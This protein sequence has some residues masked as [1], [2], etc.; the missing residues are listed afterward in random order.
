MKCPFCEFADTRVVETR[1]TTEDVTRRRREC[2]NCKKRFTTY[3]RVELHPLI[4]I[5]KAGVREAFDR[6]KVKSGVLRSCEKRPVSI[7]EIEKLIDKIESELR[8]ADKAEVSSKVV[9]D[10]A[11]RYLKKLDKI[12]YIRFASVYL[13]FED[14][15]LFREEAKKL[16]K[17]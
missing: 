10:L 6:Q 13:E 7:D 17:Q 9:G 3:E 5:K 15:E 8:K 1:E 11:M 4:I 16:M 14:V 12:A 2:M